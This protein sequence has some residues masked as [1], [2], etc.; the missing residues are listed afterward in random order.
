VLSPER[1][2][3]SLRLSLLC[4]VALLSAGPAT[5]AAAGAP[6]FEASNPIP[7]PAAFSVH[8][9]NGYTISVYAEPNRE[10]KPSHVLVT[11]AG[12]HGRV[13]VLAS[14]DLSG[15]GIKADLG[16]FGHLD[17]AWAPSGKAEKG[18]TRCRT[19]RSYPVWFAGGEYV[20]SFSFHGEGG[21]TSVEVAAIDGRSGWWRYLQC[22]IL[23]S[24]GYPGPGILLDAYR[25]APDAPD[26]YRYLSVVQNKPRAR[27]SY[28]AGIGERRGALRVERTAWAEGGAATLSTGKGL[29]TAVLRPP[30]PFAGSAV[31]KRS[32]KGGPGTWRGSLAVDFPGRPDVSLAGRGW[33]ATLMHGSREVLQ[34]RTLHRRHQIQLAVA[35]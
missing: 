1:V 8:G 10:S 7:S 22:G 11:A 20:G 9:T 28:G 31:F 29:S 15:D 25:D 30:R 13:S 21:F 27:V 18:M 34:E 35:K 6:G 33:K 14:A 19:S 12:R 23:V 24:E 32:A 2:V 4:F 17:M 3:P 16:P 26:R 5:A